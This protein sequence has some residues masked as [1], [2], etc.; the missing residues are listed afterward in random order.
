MVTR[1]VNDLRLFRTAT[2]SSNLV[3]LQAI[4]LVFA[5][6][7]T[8]GEHHANGSTRAVAFRWRLP[9]R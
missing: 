4:E 5:N 7:R 2:T 1:L 3:S 9:G 8:D 6:I